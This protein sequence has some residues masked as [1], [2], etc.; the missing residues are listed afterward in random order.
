MRGLARDAHN[1]VAGL[2]RSDERDDLLARLAHVRGLYE[3]EATRRSVMAWSAWAF[4]A[5]G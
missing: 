3:A 1:L 5:Q 4:G 2:E